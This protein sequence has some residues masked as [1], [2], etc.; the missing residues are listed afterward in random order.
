MKIAKMFRTLVVVTAAI[1]FLLPSS[2]LAATQPARAQKRAPSK[3][4]T[5]D[6]ALQKGGILVGRL[7]DSSGAPI[8]GAPISLLY[9][10]RVVAKAQT[11]KQ[12]KFTF[13]RL[14]GGVYQVAAPD[15]QQLYRLW[16]TGTAPKAAGQ[17]AHLV[18]GQ[19]VVRGQYTSGQ[20]T[21]G[22]MGRW[23]RNPLCLTAIAATAIAVPVALHNS[24]RDSAD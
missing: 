20:Y 14:R 22:R 15:A 8:A 13:S 17:V 21:G 12:G 9:S 1:G 6:V 7:V 10:S 3:S 2:L 4:L 5:E 24:D 18:A 23:L 19:P 16:A 11:N